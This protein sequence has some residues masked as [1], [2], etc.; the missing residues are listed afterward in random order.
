[1]EAFERG[2]GGCGRRRSFLTDARGRRLKAWTSVFTGYASLPRSFDMPHE[3]WVHNQVTEGLDERHVSLPEQTA[4][5]DVDGHLALVVAVA[6][7][8]PGQVEHRV[9]GSVRQ[10]RGIF[11]F[12]AVER[13]ER[14]GAEIQARRVAQIVWQ[15][16]GERGF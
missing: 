8:H 14:R 1:M 2:R 10:L 9:H 16:G 4:G 6:L 3:C 11:V 15:P 13:H 5:L 12:G 7:I